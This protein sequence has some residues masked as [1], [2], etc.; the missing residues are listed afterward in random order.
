MALL[1]IDKTSRCGVRRNSVHANVAELEIRSIR[2]VIG[3]KN[4]QF[5]H[6]DATKK[7][8][9]K[10]ISDYQLGRVNDQLPSAA[11]WALLTRSADG[12]TD[13]RVQLTPPE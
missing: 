4:I 8:Q 5:L 11:V 3:S 10:E 13:S 7:G 2:F 12:I 1:M 6:P 9:L